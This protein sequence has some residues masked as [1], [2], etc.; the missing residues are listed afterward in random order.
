[1]TKI[2]QF[3][4]LVIVVVNLTA[5]S[6]FLQNTQEGLMKRWVGEPVAEVVADYG[7]PAE[8]EE[9]SGGGKIYVW[10]R[11]V[12]VPGRWETV[13]EWE[14]ALDRYEETRRYIPAKRTVE[15]YIFYVGYDG[16]VKG[17][18]IE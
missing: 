13:Y 1:M 6:H 16:L 5:C 17:V 9:R 10:E 4:L 18:R 7:P 8:I 15:R 3:L 2:V 14:P 12:T 11:K